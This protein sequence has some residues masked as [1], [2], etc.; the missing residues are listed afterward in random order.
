MLTDDEAA[1]LA[2][3]R[4]RAWG[5]DPDIVD[6]AAALARL[7]E[8]ERKAHP[9]VMPPEDGGQWRPPPEDESAVE[10]PWVLERRRL[11]HA[12]YPL[13]EPIH[14]PLEPPTP[15][16]LEDHPE[17]LA[18]RP[19]IRPRTLLAASAALALVAAGVVAGAGVRS[20]L[21]QPEAQPTP[22]PTLMA[23]FDAQPG[24]LRMPQCGDGW[25]Q[26]GTLPT[27]DGRPVWSRAFDVPSQSTTVIPLTGRRLLG[28]LAN[29]DVRAGTIA[30]VTVVSPRSA[31]LVY[32]DVQTWT[33]PPTSDDIAENGV[34]SM[35]LPVCSAADSYP[36][37]ILAP[38]PTCVTLE[39]TVEGRAHYTVEVP[40]GV[41]FGA[42][43]PAS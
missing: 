32:T 28:V 13:H 15:D 14:E 42:R 1:E 31:R 25:G 37:L 23:E 8:L 33:R 3:L 5:A 2:E 7:D 43:C 10:D 20:I 34:Q 4:R 24:V 26:W 35:V 38:V 17:L 30:D 27:P 16:P 39:F 18:E 11:D 41:E 6:D 22:T 12:S 29:L 36:G 9:F 40:V 19:R 21:F